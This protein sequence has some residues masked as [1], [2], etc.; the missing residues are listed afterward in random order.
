MVADSGASLL[1]GAAISADSVVALT[2][3]VVGS[4][5]LPAAAGVARLGLRKS[6]PS[7]DAGDFFRFLVPW[8]LKNDVRRVGFVVSGLAGE[9]PAAA[10]DSFTG[11]V[12]SVVVPVA[13]GAVEPTG[14]SI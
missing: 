8:L 5:L 9:L 13:V 11:A 7:L 10:A 1:V 12:D 14:S 4:G 2:P 6:P 3:E